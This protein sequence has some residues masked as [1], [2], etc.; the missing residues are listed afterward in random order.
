ML[1]KKRLTIKTKR[2]IDEE[3]AEILQKSGYN[4]ETIK[5]GLENY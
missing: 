1:S 4:S 5:W 3:M 2:C